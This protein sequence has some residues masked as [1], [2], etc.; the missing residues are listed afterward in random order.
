M[1]SKSLSQPVAGFPHCLSGRRYFTSKSLRAVVVGTAIALAVGL[2][3]S[4]SALAQGVVLDPTITTYAGTGSLTVTTGGN[5][6]LATAAGLNNP[7]GIAYD[8]FGNTY[9][10][11]YG[12]NVIRVV[13][14]A[15][16]INA[17]AGTGAAC[18]AG[19]GN[20]C[21]D[22][23]AASAAT[24]N[25]PTAMQFDAQGDLYIADYG[26][27]RIRKITATNGVITPAS[28]VSTVAGTGVQGDT[29]DNNNSLATAAQLLS[30]HGIA[31]DQAGDLWISNQGQNTSCTVGYV[32]AV[33]QTITIG[34]VATAL[35]AGHYYT[36]AGVV[37]VCGGGGSGT[38]GSTTQLH[39]NTNIALDSAN[40][41][42]I[43][44]Y[45]NGK[46]RKLVTTTGVIST[47]A[48]TVFQACPVNAPTTG[49]A[50]AATPACGDGGVATAATLNG[51]TGVYIDGADDIIIGDA[52]GAR[53]REIYGANSAVGTPG[54]ITTVAGTSQ[55]CT[56]IAQ[57]NTF[58]DGAGNVLNFP[59]CGDGGPATKSLVSFPILISVNP[60]G[61]ILYVDQYDNKIR[62]INENII[63]PATNVGTTSASQNLNLQT[64]GAGT[65]TITSIT[66]SNNEF[67]L[68]ALAGCTI[69]TAT[70]TNT[71]CT[72][73]VTFT[74]AY[75]GIQTATVKVV[76]NGG[77]FTYGVVGIGVAPQGVLNPGN[78]STVAGTGAA[79]FT[80][81]TATASQ[82][83]L[84]V[85]NV[86]FD[87]TGNYYFADFGSNTVRKVTPAGVMSVYA[88]NGTAGATGDGGQATAAELNAPAGVA[89]DAA[90]NLYISDHGNNKVRVVSAATGIITTFITGLTG[91]SG[92]AV[93]PLTQALYIADTGSNEVY[94]FS[95]A[96]RSLTTIVGTG[97][98][99]A[100]PTAACGDGGSGLNANLNAPNGVAFDLNGNLFIAD[101]GDN[102]IR[103]VVLSSGTISTVAG[104]GTAG[105]TGDGAAA[106]AA[107]L[108]NPYGLV[109]DAA[110]DLYIAE[111]N[112]NIVRFVSGSTGK[113]G[114]LAGNGTACTTVPSPSC[115]DGG[116]ANVAALDAPK[117]VGLDNSGDIYVTDSGTNRIREVLVNPA[118][119]TFPTVTLGTSAG[120]ETENLYNIGNATLTYTT[121]GAPNSNALVTTTGPAGGGASNAFTQTNAT[122]CGP[123]YSTSG[124]TTLASGSTCSYVVNFTP[125][126]APGNYTG[127]LVETDNSLY[128][129]ANNPSAKTN[130]L[131][132]TPLT[133]TVNLKG[134]ALQVSGAGD[135]VIANPNPSTYGDPNVLT[136]C[137]PVGTGANA[138]A[139]LPTGTVQFEY[140]PPTPPTL[141][142][143]PVT[144]GTTPTTVNGT[145][146]YVAT[147][148]TASLPVGTDTVTAVY[149]AGPTSG[150]ASAS[151]TVQ[152]TV[153]K[154]AV[155]NPI[156]ADTTLSQTFTAT[157]NP[158][159]N[160]T[161]QTFGLPVQLT[162]TIPVAAGNTPPTGPVTFTDGAQ[163]LG[164]CGG[165]STFTAGT[166]FVLSGIT[167]T[168]YTCSVNT[169]ALPVGNPD[170]ITATYTATDPNYANTPAL[171]APVVV[172]P[173]ATTTTLTALPQTS[174]SGTTVTITESLVPVGG[175]C[176][177]A[178]VTF[179]V[180]GTLAG[181]VVTG[182]TVITPSS[183]TN[184]ATVVASPVA[185]AAATSC[186]ASIQTTSLPLGTSNIFATEPAAGSFTAVGS[187]PVSVT[188]NQNPSTGDTV[189]V[190][191]SATPDVYGTPATISF[192]IPAVANS[193]VP[194]GTVVFSAVGANGATVVL[195]DPITYNFN[196]PP[197]NGCYTA[198]TTTP[199][200]TGTA[201]STTTL[202]VGAP[203]TVT[204]TYT[205]TAA[206]GYASGAPTT[207][208]AVQ[209]VPTS[210]LGYTPSTPTPTCGV[211]LVTLTDTIAPVD[212]VLP[213]G[214]VQFY[215]IVNGVAQKIGAPVPVTAANNGVVS[216]APTAIPCGTTGA[217][218][219]FTGSGPYGN[220]TT[221]TVPLATQSAGGDTVTV[222]PSVTPDIYGDAATI[223]FSIPVVAGQ[224]APVGT[225][226]FSAVG[227]NGAT[228]TMT[229]PVT[230]S[231]GAPVNGF[232]TATIVT[233]VVTGTGTS[234]TTLPVGAPTTVTAT[235]TATGGGY[236]SSTPTTT[237]LVE[238]V[239]T[240]TL[241]YTP[242]T[243]TPTCG[244]TLVTLTDTI[245]PVDGV[246]P[247]GSVQ[248]YVIVNGVA[249]AIGSPVPVTAANN[250]VVSLAPTAIPCGTTGAYGVFTGSGPYGNSTTPT[251][252]LTT[253][254][255]GGDTVT[256]NPSPTVFGNPV[257]ITFCI[258]VVAGQGLP[259]GTVTFTAGGVILNTTPIT[260]GTTPVNGCYV[261]TTTTT[262]LPVGSPTTVTGTYTAGPTSG[263]GSG[264]PTTTVVVGPV[265]P[266]SVIN[267]GPPSPAC[268][269]TLVTL[270]DTINPVNG[271]PPT[272]TVQFYAT[273]NGVVTPLGTPQPVI[274]GV[275][276]LTIALPC[277]TTGVYGVYTGNSPYGTSTTPTA[278]LTLSDFTI[279]AT[280]PTATVN[281]GDTV[282]YTVNLAGAGGVAFTSPV[283]LTASGL[284]PGATVK[285]GTAT[286]V[287]GV[288]PT[289]TS[290]TIVTSP[291]FALLQQPTRGGNGIYLGLLLLPLLGIRRIRKKI[292]ALPRGVTYCLAAL[293]MLAG[294]G[295]MTGCNGGYFGAAPK[296]FVI[297]V[298]GTSGTLTHSTTVTLTI[299]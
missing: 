216:L 120:N 169:S 193:A 189:T 187:G 230:Y 160:P 177:T 55:Q 261:A 245:V 168:N 77:T 181:T 22:G 114:T 50:P 62:E 14:S 163:Q 174:T 263:Y 47:V 272:G 195:T 107:E 286:Y 30:P 198:T 26:D 295:A 156:P 88:G 162:Y 196:N 255:S 49:A 293:V 294:L 98:A 19:A 94:E 166:T 10:A 64:I 23:G 153:N 115:G 99:C 54:N 205:A 60:Q 188:V 226:V 146:C 223:T 190:T 75:P 206:S 202:P 72:T 235:F 269:S 121:P 46:V 82:L 80:N 108:N 213:T 127:T 184:P 79:G 242:S 283:T 167:Y 136:F 15:G 244:V 271:V 119:L 238:A 254:S 240:S 142:N 85:S 38:V 197:V 277:G 141:I 16:V 147:T 3:T 8:A 90:G 266:T 298:T 102:R 111:Q 250:G 148:T 117:G 199:A 86:V 133:Q 194:A 172:N 9:I 110:D 212:G 25:N 74:P 32:P 78:L 33:A 158:A 109:V 56:N 288:G 71:V 209:A 116:P 231:F 28:I 40:N 165:G 227:A 268:G 31:L 201:T 34:G 270:T 17:F 214:S 143:A 284:P 12:N 259:T 68:G 97:T 257:V 96:L 179:Y 285:F 267:Y 24:F 150:Y 5:G 180:G 228:V 61:N 113:I 175:V 13:N 232:Y 237:Q 70:A 290:M 43:G 262:N 92:L 140:S 185:P 6:G 208:Q 39:G 57:N 128:S 41:L 183:G 233:P 252:P 155:T 191:P 210:T 275:A 135:T 42:Y 131:Y 258:P 104:T 234:T 123:I 91:P 67:T 105:Y 215:V 249:Q 170:T 145:S 35:T 101:S 192:C 134:A 76:T 11:D 203:T 139:A 65:T 278:P 281:P 63:F 53:V 229:D 2:G 95:S 137:I 58:T 299:E 224:A 106:T 87:S 280:P 253:Q 220:S 51:P 207:T 182:G 132:P 27:N 178:P 44:D 217:Y 204:A 171:T 59:N 129:G 159:T 1:R 20:A 130:P 73:P 37:G 176:P 248:F 36:V 138:G 218:G 279:A 125:D 243:P 84:P 29:N 260:I 144:I 66:V 83:N 100:T 287:P 219:V 211:T 126:T 296:T 7:E 118:S 241:G 69:G 93:N 52:F 45:Q 112:N 18:P 124:A 247:T 239:P 154:G 274:N 164:T 200:V 256:A 276:T 152:V 89:L 221:P 122:T 246:L 81:G 225:V 149:T 222:T 4:V 282:V 289:P 48:G 297:T 236:S 273:V 186:I 292:Q 251:A 21:G 265:N 151:P 161:T 173:S 264:A 291:T 157:T 103:K